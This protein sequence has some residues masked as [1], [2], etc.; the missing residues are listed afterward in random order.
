MDLVKDLRDLGGLTTSSTP[1]LAVKTNCLSDRVWWVGI[2]E[3]RFLLAIATAI[4][5]NGSMKVTCSSA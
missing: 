5:R 4:G 3:I 1:M 2:H